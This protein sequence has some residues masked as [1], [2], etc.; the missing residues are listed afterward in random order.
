LEPSTG[1][2]PNCVTAVFAFPGGLFSLVDDRRAGYPP[3]ASFCANG[4]ARPTTLNPIYSH[5]IFARATPFANL[6][7]AHIPTGAEFDVDVQ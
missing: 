6:T 4:S 1:C 3:R 7:V 2:L 5:E